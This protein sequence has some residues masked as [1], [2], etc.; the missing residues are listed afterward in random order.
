MVFTINR[1]GFEPEPAIFTG[2]HFLNGV[3]LPE[4]V[5]GAISHTFWHDATTNA[6]HDD[7]V[8]ELQR[9]LAW[10]ILAHKW[11]WTDAFSGDSLWALISWGKL[12]DHLI[13][14]PLNSHTMTGSQPLTPSNGQISSE[15]LDSES[16]MAL[17]HSI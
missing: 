5:L 11:K 4:S 15:S 9:M 1:Q 8:F 7:V 3:S 13:S 6:L 2:S 14:I 16:A 12:A 17:Q 10:Q